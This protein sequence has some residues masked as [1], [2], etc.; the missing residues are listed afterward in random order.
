[1]SSLMRLA[2]IS[3]VIISAT[4]ICGGVSMGENQEKIENVSIGGKAG[5]RAFPKYL[6]S[7]AQSKRLSEQE[8]NNIS[9]KKF[10]SE[11]KGACDGHK[12]TIVYFSK[13][14]RTYILEIQFDSKPTIY[15]L[16]LCTFT[17]TM[18][19]DMIDG[20]FA[21]DAEE[22]VLSKELGMRSKRLE[23]YGDKNEI[24]TNDYLTKRGYLK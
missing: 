9:D 3:I 22:Y 10:M 17:P 6:K 12:K 19:M 8:F 1:M 11:V 7:P 24:E 21:Q 23:I 14:V 16:S 5:Y 4:I 18:G 13:S 15:V 20:E 2:I